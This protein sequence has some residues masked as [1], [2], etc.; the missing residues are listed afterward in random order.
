MCHCHTLVAMPEW[1]MPLYSH[2]AVSDLA[3]DIT[4]NSSAVAEIGDRLATIDM[5]RK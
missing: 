5:G 2:M 1:R 4:N 3:D